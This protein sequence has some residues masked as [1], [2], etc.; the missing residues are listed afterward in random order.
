MIKR[1]A[2]GEV[3]IVECDT[4]CHDKEFDA[5]NFNH[6]I[7]LIKKNGWR[8]SKKCGTWIHICNICQKKE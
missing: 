4:C 6:L 7:I 5:E 1:K 2:D 8:I 3:G